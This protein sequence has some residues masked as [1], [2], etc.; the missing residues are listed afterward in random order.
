MIQMQKALA[1]L[2]VVLIPAAGAAAQPEKLY[3]LGEVKLSSAT[4]EPMGSQVI[5]VEKTHDRDSSTIIERAIFVHPD[6]KVEDHTM[7]LA[8]KE[9]NSFTLIDDA[10][11]VEGGGKLFGPAWKW[12]YFKAT[13]KTKSGVTIEDENFMADDSVGS[14]RQKVIGPDDKVIMYIDVSLKGITPKTFDIL[15]AALSKK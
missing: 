10:K 3:F 2:F 7:H 15:R 1:L 8:V 5:L 4:G 6:G 11:R 14:A 13:F 12:T 9:D